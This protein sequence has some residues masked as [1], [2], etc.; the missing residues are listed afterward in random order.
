[1]N[2]QNGVQ[3]NLIQ[4][5]IFISILMQAMNCFG[6]KNNGSSDVSYIYCDNGDKILLSEIGKT[7][8]YLKSGSPKT[9]CK[10]T[11]IG[12]KEIEFIKDGSLHDLP[13]SMIKRIVPENDPNRSI[14]FDTENKPFLST[15]YN[16]GSITR[17]IPFGSEPKKENAKQ[18]NDLLVMKNGDSVFCTI[19][20][21]SSQYVFCV[22]NAVSRTISKNTI[23]KIQSL[24]T[25]PKEIKDSTSTVAPV[26]VSDVAKNP[27]K[28]TL[29]INRPQSIENKTLTKADTLYLRNGEKLLV[30]V[31][32]IG[33]STITYSKNSSFQNVILRSNAEKI[34]LSSG[35]VQ[36]FEEE[37]IVQPKKVNYYAM[38][39][40]DAEIYYNAGGPMAVG[41]LSGLLLY[42]GLILVGIVAAFPPISL[43]NSANPNNRLLLSNSEY[44]RGYRNAAHRKKARRAFGGFLLGL[45]LVALLVVVIIGVGL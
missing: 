4:L 21:Q 40:N 35:Y 5:C 1:M 9:K 8:L 34:V 32:E 14:S 20:R 13:I 38:G 16:H 11:K 24:N 22:E 39:R 15:E 26:Q 31:T 6:Q 7:T 37:E 43:Y 30:H 28:D 17:D 29:D 33:T 19:L 3:K 2:K 12:T 10:I 23:S 42:F 41:V 36:L 27:T 44:E 25:I 45:C 18:G